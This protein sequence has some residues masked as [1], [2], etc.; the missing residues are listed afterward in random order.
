M[1]G[2]DALAV[3]TRRLKVNDDA[4][5]EEGVSGCAPVARSDGARWRCAALRQSRR[6]A[7]ARGQR[8]NVSVSRAARLAA[9]LKRRRQALLTVDGVGMAYRAWRVAALGGVTALFSNAFQTALSR[10]RQYCGRDCV[11]CPDRARDIP[12]YLLLPT[13]PAPPVAAN[14]PGRHLHSLPVDGFPGAGGQQNSCQRGGLAAG[15]KWRWR[16]GGETCGIIFGGVI[17]YGS[18]QTARK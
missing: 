13:P 14:L 17:T 15:V 11:W 12:R 9:C 3:A 4:G 8:R 2:G 7:T 6:A 1:G 16:T 18:I 10:R 5:G